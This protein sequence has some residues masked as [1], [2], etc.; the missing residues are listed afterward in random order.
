MNYSRRDFLKTTAKAGACLANTGLVNAFMIRDR[1]KKARVENAV[2]KLEDGRI[3]SIPFWRIESGK[4]GPSFAMIASQHGNEVQGAEIALRFKDICDKELAAGTV[5][6]IPMSNILAVRS[7]RHSFN[8]GPE[9]NN[10]RNPEK[11]HNLQR[12]WPGDPGGNDTARIAYAL[13]QSVL[14]HCSHLFDIHNFNHFNAAE[15]RTEETH[16]PSRI[17]GD[18]STTRFISYRDT[19]VPEK[20]NM[21]MTQMIRKRGGSVLLME[22]SGQFRMNER[23][24]QTG[25]ST[26][27]NVARVLGMMK[28]EP[29]LIQGKRIVSNRDKFHAVKAPCSGIFMAASGKDTM[30]SIM[31]EDYIE[32]DNLLGHIIRD[33]NLETVR[34]TAPA[35]GYIAQLGACHWGLCDASLPAQHP[36]VEEGE[37]MVRIA[38]V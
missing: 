26:M 5:W 16:E 19:V 12:N 36:Y 10:E 18:V 20:G 4:E 34:I 15:A 25:L 13:D 1:S 24:V 2:V 29:E 31:P 11:I 38:Q 14:R 33:D 3:I 23:Q 22:L 21:M 27:T 9:E 6:L 8:L 7:R 37:I 17:M 30:T 28:G 35:S 32:K